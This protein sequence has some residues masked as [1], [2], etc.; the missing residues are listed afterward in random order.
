[1]RLPPDTV[2]LCG[3]EA[4]PELMAVWTEERLAVLPLPAPERL[5]AALEALGTTTV[6]VV[7]EGAAEAA[8]LGFRVFWLGDG[9]APE[10]VRA[11]SL[12]ETLAAARLARARER[13]KAARGGVS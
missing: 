3:A 11:V 6:V 9:P 8:A 12:A 5:E 13:W 4:P 7:G 10:G 1:M 2:L